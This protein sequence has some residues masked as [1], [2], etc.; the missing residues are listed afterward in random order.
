MSVTK[1]RSTGNEADAAKRHEP[2]IIGRLGGATPAQCPTGSRRRALTLAAAWGVLTAV[3]L[4]AISLPH[5]APA[6]KG[7]VGIAT[8]AWLTTAGPFPLL[9]MAA[10]GL[11]L[12]ILLVTA[13]PRVARGKPL[14]A[15]TIAEVVRSLDAIVWV[16]DA[17]TLQALFVSEG[18]EA[19]LGYAYQPWLADQDFLRGHIHPDDRRD[20]IARIRTCAERGRGLRIEYRALSADG[21]L[22][23]LRNTIQVIPDA[24]GR[25]WRLCGVIVD[26]TEARRREESLQQRVN[27]QA[28]VL[29][30]T[31]AALAF[32]DH[33]LVFRRV[34][35]AFAE[36]LRRPVESLEGCRALDVVTAPEGRAALQ[37]V[38]DTGVPYIA[39]AR[40]LPSPENPAEITYWDWHVR[41]VRDAQGNIEGL[42]LSLMDV[43]AAERQRRGA[44][45][46]I[47][48]LRETGAA[49]DR[50]LAMVAHELRNPIAA[51]HSGLEALHSLL[52][53]APRVQ[54]T[55]ETMERSVRLQARLVNDL[56]QFAAMRTEAFAIEKEP[57]ALDA[58]VAAAVDTL[59]PE[60]ERGALTLH[61]EITPNLWIRGDADRIQQVITN[62]LV[63]A[64][65]F[66]PPEGEVHVAVWQCGASQPPEGA[67]SADETAPAGWACLQ[68][69]DTGMGI[70]PE[71]LPRLFQLFT[72]G[73]PPQQ[74]R[75]GLGI[76]LALVQSIVE[77]HGGRV[78]AYSDGLGKGSRFLVE[79]PLIPPPP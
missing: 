53:D 28:A 37:G 64:I 51:V 69:E 50:F 2:A 9:L 68:V 8:T 16:A 52:P 44:A 15:R 27:L 70:S 66:T 30:Q 39:R 24:Q 61:A 65:K 46:E 19:L 36:I 32:L 34:N 18:T 57:V 71:L 74:G 3:T 49:K 11:S 29:E 12:S 25:P 31:P 73:P 42:A 5:Y 48:A 45:A 60:A 26:V 1:I 35:T 67:A 7:F 54:H 20:V 21:N 10:A 22:L 77:R 76:G 13:R 41:P 14:G 58:V 63:N 17:T 33:D 38:R 4:H 79:L 78:H 55:L 23:C 6:D 62:L 56:A 75:R 40:P 59:R 43:T 47:A 72:Q